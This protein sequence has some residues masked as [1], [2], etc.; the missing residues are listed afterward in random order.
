M[1]HEKDR[2]NFERTEVAT[3]RWDYQQETDILA[4]RK[5]Q[6]LYREVSIVYSQSCGERE[7]FMFKIRSLASINLLARPRERTL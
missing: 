2:L 6:V 5:I 4:A 3:T 1:Q 7:L